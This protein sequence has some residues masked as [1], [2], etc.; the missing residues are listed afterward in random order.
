MFMY[1]GE[2]HVWKRG[3]QITHDTVDDP[4]GDNDEEN[5]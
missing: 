5:Y 2:S 1:Y 4:L 3:F